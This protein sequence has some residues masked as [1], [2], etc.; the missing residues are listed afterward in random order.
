MVIDLSDF[1]RLGEEYQRR[2]NEIAS[3]PW[4]AERSLIH[5]AI[6]QEFQE[7]LLD[8]EGIHMK[9][10]HGRWLDTF[11]GFYGSGGGADLKKVNPQEWISPSPETIERVRAKYA[12]NGVQIHEQGGIHGS[13]RFFGTSA[14]QENMQDGGIDF[15]LTTQATMQPYPDIKRGYFAPEKPIMYYFRHGWKNPYNPNH[16]MKPRPFGA[17]LAQRSSEKGL[18]GR[19]GSALLRMAG[20]RRG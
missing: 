15:D 1:T 3:N 4:G 9:M 18:L 20:F 12:A 6:R 16:Q 19:F 5:A 13:G 7:T 8:N 11:D 14:V 2:A 10:Q 17:W